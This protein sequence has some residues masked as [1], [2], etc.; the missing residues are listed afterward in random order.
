MTTCF[1]RPKQNLRSVFLYYPH[2]PLVQG[3]NRI[4]SPRLLFTVK[5]Y[6]EPHISLILIPAVSQ[7]EAARSA[8]TASSDCCESTLP[9]NDSAMLCVCEVHGLLFGLRRWH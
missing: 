7:R 2:R 9:H 3:I 8:F 1:Q 4:Q 6:F 5:Q